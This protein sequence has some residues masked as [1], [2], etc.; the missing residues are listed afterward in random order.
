MS[1]KMKPCRV[2]S[3][4]GWCKE[5]DAKGR[6]MEILYCDKNQEPHRTPDARLEAERAVIEAA[7]QKYRS[8]VYTSGVSGQFA[9]AELVKAVER[10]A[11]TE[12]K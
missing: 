3:V 4:S 11:R 5:H 12:A 2:D 8:L 9:D 1:D 10:L 6:L 7:K